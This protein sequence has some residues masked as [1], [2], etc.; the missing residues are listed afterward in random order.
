MTTLPS[1]WQVRADAAATLASTESPAGSRYNAESSAAAARTDVSRRCLTLGDS[2][3]EARLRYRRD[4]LQLVIFALDE[5]LGG[6]G[7]S[8]R[9]RHVVAA[10]RG[11]QQELASVRAELRSLHSSTESH[12]LRGESRGRP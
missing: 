11:F 4:S 8:D 1:S 9:A 5:R 7:P 12:T 10:I 3:R 6:L 2:L